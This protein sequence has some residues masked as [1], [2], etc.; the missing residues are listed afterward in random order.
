MPTSGL[1]ICRVK[2]YRP[3]REPPAKIMADPGDD[4]L[5]DQRSNVPI[6]QAQMRLILRILPAIEDPPGFL[7]GFEHRSGRLDANEETA[8][9]FIQA[10]NLVKVNFI[11]TN[12]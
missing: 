5:F 6:H 9:E 10:A 7:M 4:L 3:D 2:V 8:E 1:A 12:L 11:R